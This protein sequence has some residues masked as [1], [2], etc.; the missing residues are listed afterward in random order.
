[1]ENEAGD[2]AVEMSVEMS[3]MVCIWN[4]ETYIY[5]FYFCHQN[6]EI[7]CYSKLKTMLSCH[8]VE[9]SCLVVVANYEQEVEL[10]GGAAKGGGV[11]K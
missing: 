5:L 1:M 4:N 2:V 8:D 9:K 10:G 3:A 7:A 11:A 6:V